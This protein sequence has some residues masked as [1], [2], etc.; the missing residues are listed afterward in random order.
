MK[1]IIL[2]LCLFLTCSI[3]FAEKINVTVSSKTYEEE[4]SLFATVTYDA[5]GREVNYKESGGYNYQKTYTD[6]GLLKSFKDSKGSRQTYTY[7]ADGNPVKIDYIST[8]NGYSGWTERRVYDEK[9]TL[10]KSTNSNTGAESL[11]E[12]NENGTLLAKK[13]GKKTVT[14]TYDKSGHLIEENDGEGNVTKYLYK[15]DSL[16][17]LEK[18]DGFTE[19]YKYDKNLNLIL[20]ENS[21]GKKESFQY[22]KQ[23]LLSYR[24]TEDGKNYFYSYTFSDDGQSPKE[25]LIYVWDDKK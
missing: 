18:S 17:R 23:G 1:K 25:T 8:A 10:T 7:N 11:Y 20:V 13:T 3:F 4:V 16:V 22:N 5:A 2:S 12:Y 15:K 21:L 14:Y 24:H 6:K 9:G 19:S